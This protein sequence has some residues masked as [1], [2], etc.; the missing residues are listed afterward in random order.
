[1]SNFK[2]K[3]L[4]IGLY[5]FSLGGLFLYSFTQIDLSLTVS[6]SSIIQS[7]EKSFQYIGYFNRPLSAV[8]VI[9]VFSLL[10]ISYL[11]ILK[12]IKKFSSKTIWTLIFITALVGAVSYNA[13]SY[14]LF[15][16]IF[17]A[18]IVTHYHLNPYDHKALDFPGDPMLSFMHWTHRTYPYGPVW[19]GITIPASFIGWGY[20]VPTFFLFKFIALAAYI[21]T[22][23]FIGKILKTVRP[24]EQLLGVAFFAL[25]PF[26][27]I[28]GLVSAHNDIVMMFFAVVSLFFVVKK[29][30]IAAW[31]FF[32][33]F[34]GV[35]I[36]ADTIPV[37]IHIAVLVVAAIGLFVL[38]RSKSIQWE[39]FFIILT[40]LM[41][42]PVV[43]ASL[44]T[45]FQ[46]WYLLFLVPIAA[47]VANKYI[48]AVGVITIT[49]LALFQYIPFFYTGNYDP[50]IP[51]IM[52]I[53]LVVSILISV[54][55]TGVSM[56]A[57]RSS[58]VVK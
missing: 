25:N 28:E 23:Y 40:Y 10:L 33:L 37:P 34:Y 20:F 16:Y 19:L 53:L 39:Q 32:V 35:K 17:D 52:Q 30:Y 31:I 3:K 42:L 58:K 7:L 15:N 9:A 46:P 4:L 21:G 48:V 18:K 24:K 51:Q 54:F 14:D 5:L 29:N 43:F 44:R 47:L 2:F 13:F 6:R 38:S 50:P 36:A 12:N 22:A 45:T 11:L 8:L 26:V 55:T 41:V 57:L 27:I 1:M 49:F 56:L